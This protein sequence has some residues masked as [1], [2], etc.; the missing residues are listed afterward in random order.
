MKNPYD[1][2]GVR[3]GA[4]REEINAAYKR[5]SAEY[6]RD[7]CTDK[8]D[9]LNDAYDDVIINAKQGSYSSSGSYRSTYANTGGSAI[10]DF[11]D[12]RA[13]IDENRLED[14]L[15]I[16]DGV[17][18]SRR[19]AQWY[20]LK[21]VIYQRKG[22]LEEAVKLFKKATQKDPSNAT[23]KEAYNVAVNQQGGAY[24]STGKSSDS[25]DGCLKALC[26][27]IMLDS[28]CE[29]CGCDLI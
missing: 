24:R 8:L 20:Y 25:A 2:L 27:L 17:P 21:G 1:I 22:W 6:L 13:K 18:E 19:D 23:Y 9:E 28:C 4:T 10:N 14:A 11:S 16:L 15:V 12:I 26:G 7:N 3:P 5:K 29:C